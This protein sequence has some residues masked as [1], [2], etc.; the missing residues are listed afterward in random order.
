MTFKF[1]VMDL[2]GDEFIYSDLDYSWMRQGYAVGRKY[3]SY[4]DSLHTLGVF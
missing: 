3:I 2:C 1:I 4:Y